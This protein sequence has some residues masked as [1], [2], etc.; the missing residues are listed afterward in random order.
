MTALSPW[1]STRFFNDPAWHAAGL[2]PVE[3]LRQE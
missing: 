3:A 2:D 1:R